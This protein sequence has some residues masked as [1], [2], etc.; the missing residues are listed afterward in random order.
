MNKEHLALLDHTI[1]MIKNEPDRS[2]FN[3]VQFYLIISLEIVRFELL[4]ENKITD[5]SAEALAQ[6][7]AFQTFEMYYRDAPALYNKC[8][9]LFQVLVKYNQKLDSHESSALG[10]QD[11]AWREYFCKGIGHLISNN[12]PNNK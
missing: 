4:T 9:S 5:R 8:A 11:N 7:F 2:E 12:A 1:A 10:V 6:L 3:K